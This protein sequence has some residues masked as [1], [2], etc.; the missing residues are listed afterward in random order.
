MMLQKT[1]I[2]M[3]FLRVL[4][5]FLTVL[6][7]NPSEA[8]EKFLIER[9]EKWDH[10]ILT[11]FKKYGIFPYKITYSK[12]G[13]CPVFHAKFKRSP[14]LNAP[15]ADELYKVYA[16]ALE[17]NHDFPYTLISIEDD[18]KINVG[19]KDGV[20]RKIELVKASSPTTCRAKT[21][22]VYNSSNDYK[23]IVSPKLK[24]KILLSPFKAALHTREG[25]K[26]ISYLY[27][28]NKSEVYLD[29]I[30][31]KIN[32]L[33]GK[34][35]RYY[36]Y[37]YDENTQAFIPG[38]IAI[39]SASTEITLNEEATDL[40]VLSGVNKNQSDVLLV[41][42]NPTTHYGRYEAYGFV[43]NQL[44]LKNY[45]FSNKEKNA[46][47]M[48]RAI[49]STANSGE[50]Y[51]YTPVND[52]KTRV[53]LSI[54]DT[55][56]EI[57]IDTITSKPSESQVEQNEPIGLTA[58]LVFQDYHIPFYKVSYPTDKKCPTFYVQLKSPFFEKN[59]RQEDMPTIYFEILSVNNYLP[60]AL[61]DEKQDL[62]INVGWSPDTPKEI[63]ITRDKAN[64][65]STCVGTTQASKFIESINNNVWF[66]SLKRT[67]KRS[68]GN[69]FEISLFTGTEAPKPEDY[70]YCDRLKQKIPTRKD[71]YHIYLYDF[72]NG[73]YWPD[74]I[75]VFKNQNITFNNVF[76][77]KMDPKD[78]EN[79]LIVQGIACDGDHYEAYGFTDNHSYIKQFVFAN[80]KPQEAAYGYFK[81]NQNGKLIVYNDPQVEKRYYLSPS[82][83]PGEV[84]LEFLDNALPSSKG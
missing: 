39:L 6:T 34:E 56:E 59:A 11:V 41:A 44:Y 84:N 8:S 63:I 31:N 58:R 46:I 3:K 73:S 29:H 12:D 77:M 50:V 16:E 26:F 53:K 24:E 65:D 64:S 82:K 10:P 78:K 69:L 45:L 68:D 21:D 79:I 13:R 61:V 55:P 1:F 43:K 5:F 35:G 67:V 28:K 54:S 62:K 75:E 33:Y 70:V 32:W 37:L 81:E 17:A 27:T 42:R 57:R 60:Y 38:R 80:K 19:W 15:Y 74:R 36:I 66:S 40:I 14:D 51:A 2:N 49:K 7:I 48:G 30:N 23:F 9:Y 4:F 52:K 47:F 18:I 72:V 25:K 71:P 22:N 83:I 20:S 76:I